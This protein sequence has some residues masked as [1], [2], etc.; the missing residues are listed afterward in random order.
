M[1]IYPAMRARMG[2]WNYY[3]VRM[4]MREVAR[5]VQLASK[6]WEDQTLSDAIQRVLDESRVKQQIVNYLSRR[7]DRFFASLVVAAIGGNPRWVPEA[8]PESTHSRA[9]RDTFGTLSFDEDPKYYALDGQHRLKAIQELLADPA[10]APPGFEQ[11]QISVLVVVREEQELTEHLWLQR[12]RRLFSSLNRYAKAT[13]RDTNIIMDEDDV[14]AI[15]TRRLITD[16]SFFRAPGPE[17]SSFRVQTK[18]KN[19]KEGAPHF[20]SLQSLYDV[21]RTLLMTAQRRRRRGRARDEKVFL[22]FRPEETQID[23]WYE[24]LCHLW[25]AILGAVPDLLEEPTKMRH[26]SLPDP[27]PDGLRDHLVFWPIGQQLF[28]NVLRSLLDSAGLDNTA[29]SLE[30]VDALRPMA[31]VP[32]DLHGAPW[33]YLLLVAKTADEVSWRMR[34]EDR[35]L[36][37]DVAERLL[38]WVVGLDALGEGDIDRLRFDWRDALIVGPERREGLPKPDDLWSAVEAARVRVVSAEAL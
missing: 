14:F 20:I 7:E 31:A 3:M 1:Q 11:E 10:G 19:L 15:V 13:D 21:N 17:K 16:H 9:F 28:A 32:W 29:P 23:R 4:T 37:L 8:L 18:G 12:Y 34:S 36:A 26:H 25:D 30:L 5:E 24:E 6:L 35:K 2:D 22:Q 33:R 27:N 38:R